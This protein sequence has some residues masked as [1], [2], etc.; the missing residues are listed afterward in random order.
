LK[1]L[2]K[3]VI[4]LL[5][6]N[7]ILDAAGY[8][9]ISTS[10]FNIPFSDVII[11]SILFSIIALLTL[12]IFFRGQTRDPESQTLYSLVAIGLKFLLEMLLALAW[13][14][15]VKKT[16]FPSVFIFFVL[17]LSLTLFSVLIILK[18]LRNK[19]L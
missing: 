19:S 6:L 10:K 8:L 11:L 15:V 5:L 9:F 3:Y 12:V 13:F 18:V 1:P 4:L 2:H 14:I 7:V 16:S 17:Y